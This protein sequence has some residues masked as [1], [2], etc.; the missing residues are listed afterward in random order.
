MEQTFIPVVGMEPT[1][2]KG[3]GY[4]G[5]IEHV[6]TDYFVLRS[7]RTNEPILI[8]PFQYHNFFTY[9]TKN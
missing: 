4:K 2:Y 8:K 3:N 7:F 6:G 5:V 1:S 9:K